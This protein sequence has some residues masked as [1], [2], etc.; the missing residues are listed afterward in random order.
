[1]TSSQIALQTREEFST[2]KSRSL[3]RSLWIAGANFL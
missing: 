3:A 2:R 1:M